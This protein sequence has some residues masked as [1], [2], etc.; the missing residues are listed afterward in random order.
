MK[1]TLYRLT[2]KKPEKSFEYVKTDGEYIEYFCWN[3]NGF[4]NA[5]Y[6]HFVGE[7]IKDSEKKAIREEA[8]YNYPLHYPCIM[9]IHS[10]NSFEAGR[11]IAEFEYE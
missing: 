1:V 3:Q 4:N 6:D 2:H 10:Y 8:C 7:D 5:L 9:R 11:L